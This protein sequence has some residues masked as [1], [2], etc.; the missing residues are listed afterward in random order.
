MVFFFS[1]LKQLQIDSLERPA[2]LLLLVV[3]VLYI[4]CSFIQSSNEMK[5]IQIPSVWYRENSKGSTIQPD[6][7]SRRFEWKWLKNSRRLW[8][9]IIGTAL[10]L[11][12]FICLT[13]AIA[14]P[15]GGATSENRT[16]GIDIYFTM[17]MSASMK[18][19]DYSL[20]EI[21]ARY[22]LDVKTP[23]RFD[24]AKSTM[25]QFIE[26]RE[27]RCHDHSAVIARCD[28]IGISM[29][30]QTAFIDIP[31]TTDYAVLSNHLKLRKIDDID[32][33]QL[34]IG[35]GIM[36]AVASL[37]HSTA[38]SK[39]IILVS[40]GDRKGGRISINQA[41][42]AANAYDVHIFPIMIGASNKA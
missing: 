9:K 22:R 27:A 38:K 16:E 31:L 3:P 19:Y 17:D 18:A 24:T 42:A 1:F 41:L 35:D 25:L 12:G 36:S 8:S 11:F 13:I 33:T 2:L 6:I 32:A 23:N 4:V 34:A 7:K 15:Y 10:G 20:D 37:R 39:N 29:F 5:R 14:N 21:Q 26:S 30:G 28:R 40:D